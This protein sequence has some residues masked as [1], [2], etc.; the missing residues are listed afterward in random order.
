QTWH[1]TMLKKIA[2]DRPGQGIRA[3]IASVLEARRWD[4]LLSQNTHSTSVFRS[5]YRYRGPIWQEGYPRD[6]DL[7]TGEGAA[8][9]RAR[10]GIHPSKKVLLYAP[11]WR[12]DRLE[13]I[14]HLDVA[15]FTEAVGPDYVTLIRGHSRT[16]RPGRDVPAS[17]NVI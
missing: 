8:A 5:A 11:T 7:A 15:A 12:D 16:L 2:N 17:A 13:H 1:G 10:L 14:D 9:V 6:D 3:S 4:V